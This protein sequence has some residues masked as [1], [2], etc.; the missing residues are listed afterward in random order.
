MKVM[1]SIYE[2]IVIIFQNGYGQLL[3]LVSAVFSF[4]LEEKAAFMIVFLSVVGDL[5]WGIAASLKLKK[6]LL[7]SA[8]RET[9]VKVGIYAFALSGIAMIEKILHGGTLYGLLAS[10]AIA[11]ACELWSI[12][13]N[14]LM[15]KPDM[16]FLKIF[17]LQLKGEIE[18]KLGKN[19]SA[20]LKEKE[21]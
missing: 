12:S 3:L 1:L 4:T 21:Q 10:C 9:L 20:F 8:I 16:P 15:V 17:R 19:F 7:S 6:F 18:T 2:H 14:M 11:A 5:F 13:A